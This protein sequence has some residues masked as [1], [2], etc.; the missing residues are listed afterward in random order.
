MSK[1]FEQILRQ[2]RYANKHLRKRS[3]VNRK[4][5][6]KTI[7][8]PHTPTRKA[9]I[10]RLTVTSVNG[11]VSNCD[12]SALRAGVLSSTETSENGLAVSQKVRHL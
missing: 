8:D 11:H 3:L 6:S 9:K 12:P 7:G 5:Q 10:K 2:R 1:K 4:M